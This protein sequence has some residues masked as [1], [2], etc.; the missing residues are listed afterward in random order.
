MQRMLIGGVAALCMAGGGLLVWQS[1]ATEPSLIPAPPPPAAISD[2]LPVAGSDAPNFGPAHPPHRRCLK[3]AVRRCVSTDMKAI[4][5][6]L[7]HAL[8]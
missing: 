8:K 4:R 7:S 3:P 6:S 5:M 1:M 2:T